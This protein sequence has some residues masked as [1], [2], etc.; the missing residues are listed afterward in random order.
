MGGYAQNS[1]VEKET[2][3]FPPFILQL[4]E[5]VIEKREKMGTFG[6]SCGHGQGEAVLPTG[7]F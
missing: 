5:M 1:R 6:L 7:L 4:L 2:R 3:S